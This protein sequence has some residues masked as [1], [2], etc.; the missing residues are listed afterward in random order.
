MECGDTNAITGK[1]MRAIIERDKVELGCSTSLFETKYK[2]HGKCTTN[3]WMALT[4]KF[5][6]ENNFLLKEVAPNLTPSRINNK[7]LMKK[8]VWNGILGAQLETLNQCRLFLK[9]TTLA[10]TCT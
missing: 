5:M 6:E 10:N 1:Q 7:F 9:V 4:W 8:F 2:I 3:K